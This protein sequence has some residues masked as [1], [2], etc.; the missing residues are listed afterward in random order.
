MQSNQLEQS[1]SISSRKLLIF[2]PTYN[3]NNNVENIL[4]Q[5][6]A[7][8]INADILFVDD[9]SPDGTGKLLDKLAKEYSRLI[10]RHRPQK[11][12]IGSAHRDGIQWA[13]THGYDLMIT[14]DCDATHPP[15]YIPDFINA[16]ANYD[17]VV[18]SRHIQDSSLADW[19][20]KRKFLTKLGHFLTFY[21]LSI[22]YDATG[23]FRIYNLKAI[24][25]SFLQKVRSQG[26]SFFFESLFVLHRNRF[27]IGEVAIHLPSRINDQSK[28]R[29]K[30]IFDSLYLL[31][32]LLI[33]KIFN[34]SKFI[35]EKSH[36]S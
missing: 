31:V 1:I 20:L 28:M 4:N 17:I 30:D 32:T 21:C 25:E 34:P 9:N 23:A 22:P 35:I 16:S 10:T 27:R 5:I 26:Y 33:E 2:V 12:G 7:L 8:N 18:G 14:L 24:P 29:Y 11:L 19:S 13:Y 3:E 15:E 36:E 6:L